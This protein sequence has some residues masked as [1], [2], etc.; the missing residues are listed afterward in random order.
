MI[1]PGAGGEHSETCFSFLHGKP[2]MGAP[3]EYPSG[4]R[5]SGIRVPGRGFPECGE[6]SLPRRATQTR[7]AVFAVLRCGR[8]KSLSQDWQ[9]GIHNAPLPE[10]A[11]RF[12]ENLGCRGNGN[13]LPKMPA[14][15]GR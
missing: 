5:G 4:W 7:G 13:R 14:P 3:S 15:G 10:T 11:R 6:V 12:P 2:E 9:P 8:R 1:F